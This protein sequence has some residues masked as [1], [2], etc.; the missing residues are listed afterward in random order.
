M[1]SGD[2]IEDIHQAHDFKN[3]IAVVE[4]VMQHNLKNV[5]LVYAFPD[6][7]YDFSIAKF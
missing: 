7:R 6:P 1:N 3:G 4:F 5:E 2:W